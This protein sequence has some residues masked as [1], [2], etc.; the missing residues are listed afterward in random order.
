MHLSAAASDIGF[1]HRK[2]DHADIYFIANTTNH[3]VTATATFRAARRYGARAYAASLDTTSGN[4][5]ALDPKSITLSLAPYES[6]VIL[7]SDTPI[8]Q[9]SP[10]PTQPPQI[11]ADLS[12]DW[13]I[14]FAHTSITRTEQN[15]TSW[16]D[17]LQT[18][19]YSGV[20]TYTKTVHLTTAQLRGARTFTLDF[21]HGTP[22]EPNPRIH[23][24]E[25]ALLEG[26]IREAAVVTIN[27]QRA[28]S[29]WHPP[30][31]LDVTQ[32]LHT[33]DNILEVQVANTAINLLAGQ[34]P[35]DYRLLDARYGE[36]FTPQDMNALQPLPS[37]I[38]G[39]IHLLE[40]K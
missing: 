19:F 27:G 11:I 3:A 5:F 31:T 8:G 28:G 25:H 32:Q 6:R 36:R 13:R 23:S 20:A 9:P 1:L 15:L 21:G 18:R 7:F 40:T 35:P 38:L 22:T 2:L 39:P 29:V 24:G 26:P 17:N 10:A 14:T 37:G 33:G 30:Y 12:H 16:S 34:S 4:A